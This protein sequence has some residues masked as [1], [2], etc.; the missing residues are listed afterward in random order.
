MSTA[1]PAYLALDL[2]MALGLPVDAFDVYYERNGWAGTWAALLHDVRRRMGAEPC[3]EPAGNGER[4]VL[5]PHGDLM[6]HMGA[7]DVG[8]SEA[9][10]HA[11]R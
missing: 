11:P 1:P 6:P 4:C 3:W 10:P 9:L 8:T 7:S 5:L 2:W